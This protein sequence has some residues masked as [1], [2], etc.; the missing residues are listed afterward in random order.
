MIITKIKN[1]FNFSTISEL[2][3]KLSKPETEYIKIL[4]EKFSNLKVE[5]I[6]YINQKTAEKLVKEKNLTPLELN[7]D[8]PS[9]VEQG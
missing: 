8:Y 5:Q 3:K 2:E 7:I 6:S 9:F 1:F 4:A